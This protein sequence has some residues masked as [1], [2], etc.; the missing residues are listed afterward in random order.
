MKKLCI[1]LSLT[2]LISGASTVNKATPNVIKNIKFKEIDPI[3]I[4][5]NRLDSLYIELKKQINDNK[6]R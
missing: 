3:S 6:K 2:I 4:R 5:S 1:L